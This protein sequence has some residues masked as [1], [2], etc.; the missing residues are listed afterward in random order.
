MKVKIINLTTE[1]KVQTPPVKY[2]K[3]NCNNLKH[4]TPEIT[5]CTAT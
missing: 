5:N 2:D 1:I 4:T 3:K